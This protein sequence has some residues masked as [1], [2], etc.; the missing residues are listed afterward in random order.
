MR[1]TLVTNLLCF[2]CGALVER[3]L[4]TGGPVAKKRKAKKSKKK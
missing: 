4:T 1:H 2:A 3:V